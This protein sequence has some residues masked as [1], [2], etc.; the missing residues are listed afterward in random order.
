MTPAGD[1]DMCPGAGVGCSRAAQTIVE[2]G[3]VLNILRPCIAMESKPLYR[4]I[5]D[6]EHSGIH[7]ANERY[8]SDTVPAS[9]SIY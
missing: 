6:P 3:T 1:R 2:V 5:V 9:G 7:N 4:D 8:E